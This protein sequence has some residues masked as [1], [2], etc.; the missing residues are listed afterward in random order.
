MNSYPHLAQRFLNV[1]LALTSQKAELLARH[2]HSSGETVALENTAMAIYNAAPADCRP[3]EVIAGIAIISINGILVQKLGTMQLCWGMTGYDGL[4]ANLS[5]ALEDESVRAIMLDI[6]SPGGEVAGC[7]DLVDAIYRARGVKKIWAVL[8][9]CAYSAAYALA[10]AAE[11]IVVPRTGGTGSVGVICMHTDFSKALESAGINVTLIRY[12]A[13]KADG[14]EVQPLSK[15]ALARFQADVDVMGDLFVTTVAR[16]RKM[17]V[18]KV[19][20]TEAGTFLGSAGVDIGFA[21]AV[22]SPDQAFA[23]LLTEL[24]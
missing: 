1:P 4:R 15:D 7:F 10:S 19:R 13:H 11:K 2:F 16:N 24:D 18:A 14:N 9:E 6:D 3:Y 23:T 12:G 8:S 5:L 22:M 17:T 20:A 21:D